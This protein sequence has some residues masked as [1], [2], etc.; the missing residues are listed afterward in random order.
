[1]AINYYNWASG[2]T[3]STSLDLSSVSTTATQWLT[4]TCSSCGSTS[5]SLPRPRRM[6]VHVPSH[7]ARETVLAF[8]RL[9]NKETN[10]GWTINMVIWND[11]EITICDPDIEV[12]EFSDWLSLVAFRANPEDAARLRSF[13]E[14]A[15][16]QPPS[17]EQPKS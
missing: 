6:L 10:T 17:T 16:E 13:V 7:W 8:V 15:A 12:R 2:S 1:M 11:P 9:L 3:N 5:W 4:V 14:S